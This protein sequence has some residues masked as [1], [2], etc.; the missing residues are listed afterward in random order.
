MAGVRWA[1]L[2]VALALSACKCHQPAKPPVIE[3]SQ[4]DDDVKSVYPLTAPPPNPRV[5]S[6]CEALQGSAVRAAAA[7]CHH[8]PGIVLTSECVR[9]LGNAVASSAVR[10]DEGEVARC[11]G[12]VERAHQGCEWVGPSPDPAPAECV[13]ILHGTLAVGATCRSS[14]ECEKPLHCR[15][16]GP[17]QAG[18]CGPPQPDQTP[19]GRAVDPLVGYARQEAAAEDH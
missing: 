7:C 19:C 4:A 10:L 2:G 17:T 5:Q 9:V 13:G 15:G 3:R 1:G 18:T 8:A 11:V 16:V 6:L 14:F 12:A